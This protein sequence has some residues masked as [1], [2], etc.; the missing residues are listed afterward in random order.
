[1]SL[2]DFK[3]HYKGLS[4]NIQLLI[5][6]SISYKTSQTMHLSHPKPMHIPD[7]CRDAYLQ[8]QY[9][10]HSHHKI[11]VLCLM[12]KQIHAGPRSDTAA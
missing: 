2:P 5:Y 12:M 10:R 3:L 9:R 4:E 1:M 11:P 7:Q 6:F 8:D